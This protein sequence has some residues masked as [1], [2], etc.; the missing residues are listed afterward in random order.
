MNFDKFKKCETIIV[1]SL[2][3]GT[4]INLLGWLTLFFKDTVNKPSLILIFERNDEQVT[5]P[6]FI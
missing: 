6:G 3:E 1:G 4:K 2:N 5:L